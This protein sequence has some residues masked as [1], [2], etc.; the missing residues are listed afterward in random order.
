MNKKRRKRLLSGALA[1]MVCCSSMLNAGSTVWASEES[2]GVSIETE[3]GA[4]TDG[5][6]TEPATENL[7]PDTEISDTEARTKETEAEN[8]PY[9]KDV[10]VAADE[11]VKASDLT[12]CQGQEF[13]IDGNLE[14]MEFVEKKVK[15]KFLKAMDENHNA[16]DINKAGNY[17]AIY[18]VYPESG[19]QA[20]L[21]SRK[22]TVTAK[23]PETTQDSNKQEESESGSDD[24][25]EGEPE[26]KSES[27]PVSE[28][29]SKSESEPESESG[30]HMTEKSSE[31]EAVSE[32]SESEMIEVVTDEE[33]G[34]AFLAVVPESMALSRGTSVELVKGKRLPYPSNLGDYAT[35]YFYV[36]G[37]IAYC[38]QSSKEAPPDSDYIANVLESNKQLQ[39]VLYYGYG[40]PGDLT[41]KFMPH[42]D[43]DL[44]YIFTHLA[45]A[46]AYEGLAGFHGCTEEDLIE[47]GVMAYINYLNQQEAPPVAAINL[48]STSEK[49]YLDGNQQRTN[50]I[51]L[52]GDHRNYVTLKIP[53][54]VTYH[55]AD[56][57]KKGGSV[58]I[59]GGTSFY[60]T[61]DRNLTGKWE[62][63]LL[64]GN[65][66]SQYKTLVLSTG[67]TQDVAYADFIPEKANSVSFSIKWIDNAK[68]SL[69]KE[70]ESTHAGLAG[71]VFGVY[72]DAGC[73]SLITEMPKTDKQGASSV[74]FE[75]TGD[76]VYLK[77][78]TAPRGYKLNTQAYNV[79]LV[80]GG[81]TDIR[82]SNQE[83]K[84][85]ITVHKQGPVLVNAKQGNPIEFVYDNATFAGAEYHIYAA[86]DIISQDGKTKI[87]NAGDLVS[88]LKTGED[89]ST[90]SEA[91]H[92]GVYNVVEQKAPGDL[93]IGKT[94]AE[95]TQQVT[96]SYA[97]QTIE[98]SAAEVSFHNDRP[99]VQV[100]SIKKSKADS[101]T[102][103]G[104]QYGLYAG[105][106]IKAKDGSILVKKDSLIES[107]T[108][109]TDGIGTFK[110]DIPI[111]YAY[112]CKEIKAPENYYGS[113]EKFT[114]RYDYLNDTTYQ[115]T[116]SHEFVNEEVRGE[117]H[118]K[119]IDQDTNG[120]ISQGNANLAGA[121]YGIYAAED[122]HNPNLKSG[123][124]HK[125][126][127]LVQ[128]GII[129]QDGTLDFKNLY[130]GKYFVQEIEPGEGYQLD[131]TRYP[132]SVGY[133]GQDVK[134]VHRDVTVVEEIK[135]QAFQVIKIS[136]DGEQ[137]ETDLVK[138]AGFKVYLISD[139]KGVK[140]G[141]LK[142]S[143]G[144]IFSEKDFIGYDFS[145]DKTATYYKNGDIQSV[146]E[147]FT[148]EKGYFLS[149]ELPYGNYVVV[150][151]TVPE[152][153]TAVNPFLVHINED[154]REPQVWR[155]FDDRPFQFF[156]K[157]IKKDS[158]TEKP[159]LNNSASY[160]IFDVTAKK[161]V[162]MIVRYPKEEKISIFQTNDQGY[163]V[164]PE[165]LKAGTYRFEEVKAPD[166]YIKPGHEVV[167]EKDGQNIPLN[168]TVEGGTYQEA[169]K[170]SITVTIDANTAHQ[171]EPETGKLIVIIEQ[172][173][174]EACGSL[175]LN[176]KG[177]KLDSVTKRDE[178]LGGQIKNGLITMANS[179]TNLFTG[180]DVLEP[181]KGIEF[182]YELGGVQAV[183]DVYAQETIYTP[184]GQL[185]ENGNRVIRYEKDELIATLSTDN[186]GKAV[187]NNLPI[188]KFY[189]LERETEAGFIT[190]TEPIHFEVQYK[191]EEVAV[192]YIVK[193]IMNERQKIQISI[194]KKD[195][196]TKKPLEGVKFG[197]YAAEDVI[198][199]SGEIILEKGSLIEESWTDESG[200]AYFKS[201]LPIANYYAKELETIPGYIKNEEEIVLTVDGTDHTSKVIE[202]V[203]EMENDYTKVDISKVDIGGAEIAG[204]ELT[205]LD[206]AGKEVAHWV[207]DG[208][209]HR[210]ERLA[211][212]DYVLSEKLAPDG[213]EMAEDVA[214]TVLETGEIQKVSMTDE[215]IKTG[216]ISV[217]KIGDMLVGTTS[218][219]SEFG[220]IHR[221][222][223]E[224]KS[225]PGVEFTVYNEAGEV[226]DI[227][228]TTAE[229]IATSK[230][231][232]IGRY[233][234]RETKTPA[235]LAMNHK[236]Y[237]IELKKGD[238][239]KV[240]DISM[241]IE[242][243]VID[244]EINV[245]KVGEM[246]NPENG[247]FGYN[248]KP[249]EG[250]YFGIFTD[251]EIKDY[252][253]K[254]VLPKDSLIG[255]IKTN[256]EG[257]ATLRG[258]LVSGDY[259]YKE[260]K[261]LEGY[262]LDLDKHPF[263]LVLENEPLTIFD[264]NKENPALNKLIKSKITLIK[265]DASDKKRL[266]GAE[267]ELF[268]SENKS[269]G[270]YTTDEN[271]EIIVENLAY[272]DY[273]FKEKKAPAGYQKLSKKIEFSLRGKDI[274]ITC[275]NHL[276]PKLGFEDSYLRYALMVA[277]GGAVLI[278]GAAFIY[279]RYKKRKKKHEDIE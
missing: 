42:F 247:K 92:L 134:V 18:A 29:E 118:I 82:I 84:G 5:A 153:L 126:D 173:N 129:A 107:V 157:I 238:D 251:E 269:L 229:G 274:V 35:H 138:G 195:M 160:K 44:R 121:R 272:G 16:F 28:P 89:G 40:G 105:E 70:D 182:N 199:T 15:I 23:E 112:Y 277:A 246:L 55:T 20:Y 52:N 172:Y 143:N 178:E 19:N 193:D 77:E 231:L 48:S 81:N 144:T 256:K 69:V 242:N 146:P 167:L 130:L 276:V 14:G 161:Y 110:A 150:E 123:L 198:N 244:T 38:V 76:T 133:E 233:T 207:S 228:Q 163:L 179:V 41:G 106:D 102:L 26:S 253:G 72:R 36:N 212:G 191:G 236:V 166:L 257:K 230:E 240:V 128:Q 135:K 56:Q 183:F 100:S 155:V 222:T 12:I 59:Y 43:D 185:D 25:S 13:A 22:I 127:E 137:T 252:T 54:N 220:T 88:Q 97:G 114:F 120:S 94:E 149:P 47:C 51:T 190:D 263:R 214:F 124:V 116:F 156:V 95:R 79:K 142:P 223:Y 192:D 196:G 202:L 117:V 73:T 186:G 158:Q 200:T 80:A 66:G 217:V 65:I 180:E 234:L 63:G 184:D 62:S 201:D 249:L 208:K 34:N 46:Y 53:S 91:L 181:V 64:K 273:Y 154:S 243:D 221:M 262:E 248:K 151:T 57:T 2:K 141:S 68:V 109:N 254:T 87:H 83:Q 9:I 98:L 90:V 268:S 176:K 85:K 239:N 226:A 177:E 259:Y 171:V 145:E 33:D 213:Y 270:T 267:F 37:K 265:E 27:E 205:I 170:D 30:G 140:D 203:G 194:V 93:T 60:F 264:V 86:Q 152:N 3:G 165:Q 11:F 103:K 197:L 216:K 74:E 278:G 113:D 32:E 275:K 50:A 174:D 96:L 4:G 125:K 24:D 148:D 6:A 58:K 31:S 67:E 131:E 189:L 227:I 101:V 218:H 132:V 225:L 204:A 78:I 21:I 168:Q 108:T 45:A 139:L 261:T 8:L 61:A 210:I 209:P 164:T 122:I 162:E 250:I 111:G 279:H 17:T 136:E 49:A 232:P 147:L 235:G 188:G 7:F 104:A 71:A 224:K 175:T 241:D 245:Y 10:Q 211:P 260:L 99:S 1:F 271:G 115:Y 119:K 187:L 215:Y 39:K 75:K 266:S 159:V 237:E 169:A 206:S 255:A 219:D 258:A